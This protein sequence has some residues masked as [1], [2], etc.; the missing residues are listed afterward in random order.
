[1]NGLKTEEVLVPCNANENA[2]TA[3]DQKC[4]IVPTGIEPQITL[5][6]LS[7]VFHFNYLKFVLIA[8]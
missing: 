8:Y 7:V 1:M 6:M 4:S 5:S 2:S 3:V